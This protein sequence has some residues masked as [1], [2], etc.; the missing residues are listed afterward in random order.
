LSAVVAGA[1]ACLMSLSP[2]RPAQ[3]VGTVA[4]RLGEQVADLVAGEGDLFGRKIAHEFS[5][6]LWSVL[7]LADRLGVDL[8]DSFS[9]SMAE[10]DRRLS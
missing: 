6:C 1:G 9:S 2:R 3:P 8:E 4:D 5:D 7:V 10:L